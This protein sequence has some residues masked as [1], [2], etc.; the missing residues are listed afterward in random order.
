[1]TRDDY[2]GWERDLGLNKGGGAKIAAWLLGVST[3]TIRNYRHG[4]GYTKML[5]LSLRQ[6]ERMYP[7]REVMVYAAHHIGADN[8]A[9]LAYERKHPE[10]AAAYCDWLGLRAA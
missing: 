3:A 1:M 8:E 4:R 7:S 2:L 10:A 6:I 9:L 5:A